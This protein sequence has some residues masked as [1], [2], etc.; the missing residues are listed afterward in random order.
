M[1][2]C[3]YTQTFNEAYE[4]S[5]AI[6]LGEA[7]ETKKTIID[8]THHGEKENWEVKFKILKSWRLVDKNYV[9][10]E[11]SGKNLKCGSIEIGNVYLIY[12]NQLTAKLFIHP[13][14][15]TMPI[16]NNIANSDLQKLGS[17]TLSLKGG[18]FE[19]YR[20][21]IYGFSILFLIILAILIFFYCKKGKN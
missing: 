10:V 4:K 1:M 16:E 3:D 18:E 21:Q 9:W 15:R 13:D 6:F 5:S 14:S 20:T 17:A 2:E 19:D 12:A 11:T 8:T 7:I